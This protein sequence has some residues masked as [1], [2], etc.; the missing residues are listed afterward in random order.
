[1]QATFMYQAAATGEVDVISAF[2][3]DGRI[4]KYDL[5]VLSDPKQAIPP[6]D[7][8][9]LLAPD[10]AGDKKLAA[11]LQPLIG[12][13]DV[14]EMREANLRA[15]GGDVLPGAVAKWLWGRDRERKDEIG[16]PQGSTASSSSF[17]RARVRSSMQMPPRMRAMVPPPN[18]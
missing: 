16:R 17:A 14:K 13:I 6:Y 11:A 18:S 12:A 15:A 8:I 1:M 9:L 3:S 5:K 10:D 2:S 7:A 4:A